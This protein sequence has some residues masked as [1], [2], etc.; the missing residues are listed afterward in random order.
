MDRAQ[1]AEEFTTSMDGWLVPTFSVVFA[2]ENGNIGYQSAGQIPLR[3]SDERGYRPGWD[4][5]HQWIGMI[6]R[7]GMPGFQNPERGWITSAKNRTAPED[8]PYPLYGRWSSGHR[9]RRIR[10]MFEARGTLTQQDMVEMQHDVT[11]IRATE[12]VPKLLDTLAKPANPRI[13]EALSYLRSWD[14]LMD[15]DRIGATIFDVFFTHWQKS[16]V[17]EHFHNEATASAISGA[18]SGL[19]ST[20]LAGDEAGW[21]CNTDRVEAIQKAMNDALAELEERLGSDMALWNWGRLHKINLQ[22]VLS[23][24]GDLGQLLDRGGLP[25][26]GNGITVCNTGYDPNYLAPMG[27]NYRLITDFSVEP[28]GLFAVDA[29]G[30]SGHPGSTHYCD[31]LDEW[32]NARYHFIP[33]DQN[34][35]K[36]LSKEQMVLQPR[37]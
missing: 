24:R 8:F 14:Y 30:I 22:H 33:L 27:A 20:L 15:T 32:T 35:V 25:V 6:P 5:D 10:Q 18:S 19:A 7:D 26:K 31:Q 13:S 36:R 9:A 4:P 11:S 17:K 3:R 23:D 21:F 34:E 28:A 1:S 29:Q 37:A 2:D 12:C 16:V